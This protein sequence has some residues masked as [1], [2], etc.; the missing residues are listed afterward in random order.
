MSPFRL[1]LAALLVAA[2]PALAAD[3]PKPA[4]PGV[5][6]TTAAVKRQAKPVEL[7]AVG[8]VT[9]PASVAVRA[10][11]DGQIDKVHVQ[12]GAAVK[13]G[14]LLV[15]LDRRPQE[16]AVS[17]AEA[18]VA[19]SQAA[20]DSARRELKR[21]APLADREFAPRQQLD[22]AKTA[23]ETATAALRLDQANLAGARLQLSFTEIKAPV[24]GRAGIVNMPKGN[25][26]RSNDAQPLVVINQITPIEVAFALPQKE[27]PAIRAAQAAGPLAVEVTAQ[28]DPQ[29]AR[30]QMSFIDNA[31]D[32]TTGTVKLKATF[33]NQDERLWPGQLVDV[34]LV[35]A[36]Q[37][38][39]LVV[40]ASAVQQSQSGTYVYVVDANQAAEMRPVTVDR[41]LGNDAVIAK[42]VAEGEIV[43][44]DGHFRLAPGM[45]VAKGAGQ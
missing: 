31:I 20:L 17:Q 8:T 15:S 35:L 5:A 28:G 19:K 40:P 36:T 45:K 6:V 37:S 44:V 10:R 29:V 12:D 26:V 33:A 21:L 24:S 39:A 2:L 30:G 7:R 3:K 43:V 13:E 23:V 41:V 27:L 38:D 9:S 11:V 32:Q 16:V 42:G 14:A 1:T 18:A 25:L 4:G 34:R 22:N